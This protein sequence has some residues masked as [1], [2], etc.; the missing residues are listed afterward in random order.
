MPRLD[1]W[2][3]TAPRRDHL[4]PALHPPAGAQPLVGAQRR[5]RQPA[6][7]RG[8][9]APCG[10]GQVERAQADGRWEAAYAGAADIETPADLAAALTAQPRAKAMF[11]ILTSQNRYAVLYRIE[12]LNVPILEPAA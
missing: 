11:D 8:P 5:H 3:N 6:D 9:D 1:R 10:G 12:A 7:G 2:S 4:P